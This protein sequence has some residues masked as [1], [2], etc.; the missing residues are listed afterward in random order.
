MNKLADLRN[1]LLSK[2]PD[3]KR[4]PERLLTFVEDGNIEFYSGSNLSHWYTMPV[5]IIVTDWRGS[6]DDIVVPVL[7]WMQVRE[8]GMDQKNAISFETEI[9]NSKAMDLMLTLQ[10]TER[11]IVKDTELGREITHVL[12]PPAPEM[13][14]DASLQIDVTGPAGDYSYPSDL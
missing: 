1:H 5:K 8:P 4:G 2:I 11:V 12:P 6:A 7:E 14:P 10:I 3:L 9:L 13:N